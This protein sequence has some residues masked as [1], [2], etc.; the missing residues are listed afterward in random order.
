MREGPGPSRRLTQ[1]FGLNVG[2]KRKHIVGSFGCREKHACAEGAILR[3]VPAGER[4]HP[5]HVIAPY[6][7]LRLEDDADFS[8]VQ[9]KAQVG[10]QLVGIDLTAALFG[11]KDADTLTAP[12]PRVRQS[13]SRPPEQPGC[14]IVCSR[15]SDAA[16]GR[17]AD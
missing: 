8:P 17:Q 15:L 7:I 1:G 6:R 12:C 14:I 3:M 10:F 5:R 13:G 2:R 16:A 11:G 4:L 9:R